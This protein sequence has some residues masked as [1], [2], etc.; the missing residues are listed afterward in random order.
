MKQPFN[1]SVICPIV[2]IILLISCSKPESFEEEA[3]LEMETFSIPQEQSATDNENEGGYSEVSTK[4]IWSYL[5]DDPDYSILTEAIEQ[6]GYE[7]AL[8]NPGSFTFFAPDNAAF[9]SYLNANNVSSVKNMNTTFLTSLLK[10][11][12]F[13]GEER[14]EYFPGTYFKTLSE[15]FVSRVNI[16]IFLQQKDGKL[17]IN[18]QASVVQKNIK[19]GNGILNKTDAVIQPVSL[20]RLIELDP[21]L[22][23]LKS[24][25]DAISADMG[26]ELNDL[27][28]DF[29]IFAPI[30]E[31]LENTETTQEETM[32]CL[33][34]HILK[35]HII[36]YEKFNTGQSLTTWEGS[37]LTVNHES[38]VYL[39]DEAS[40]VA[41]IET[42]N[43]AAWNGLIHIVDGVFELN[44]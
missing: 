36:R 41:E 38:Q 8:D 10:M 42:A 37:N 15:E 17:M 4:S 7:Q 30:N 25:L 20:K 16:D 31:S 1:F 26:K 12:M 9:N 29:T 33:K 14:M 5:K 23:G 13:S 3:N 28:K 11:H 2:T 18:D 6:I 35:D 19:V 32:S 27:E 43:I 44:D 24:M 34:Y 40:N 39:I 22:A 21:A